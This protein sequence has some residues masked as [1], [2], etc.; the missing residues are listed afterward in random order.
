ML[1]RLNEIYNEVEAVLEA[2]V[3]GEVQGGSIDVYTYADV[4]QW[5]E[6]V[7]RVEKALAKIRR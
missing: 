2:D 6:A 3:T 5:G 7:K 4:P 1:E